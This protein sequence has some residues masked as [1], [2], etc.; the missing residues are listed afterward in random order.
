MVWIIV[1]SVIVVAIVVYVSVKRAAVLKAKA[2]LQDEIAGVITSFSDLKVKIAES[3]L[4]EHDKTP[5]IKNIDRN[6]EQL[7]RWRSTALPNITFWK[8]HTAPIEKEFRNLKESVAQ[9]LSKYDEIPKPS[10]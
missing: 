6:I 1:A 3:E 2:K 5:L 10:L 7:E 8:N 9:E 4:R